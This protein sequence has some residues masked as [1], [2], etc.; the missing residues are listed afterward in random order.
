[1]IQIT[2]LKLKIDHTKEDLKKQI[3]KQLKIQESDIIHFSI[4]K[5]SIDARKKNE[6]SIHNTNYVYSLEVEVK[7]EGKIV[8]KLHNSNIT[9]GERQKYSYRPSGNEKLKHRP[10]IAGFGPAGLFCGL[11][12]AREGYAPIILE[13]G[14]EISNRVKA[15]EH[16]WQTNELDENSNV[17]FGEGGAGTFSDG[18]LNTLVKD[19]FGRGR[20]VLEIF[21][22]HGAPEEIL[23]LNKPHIGTDKLQGVVQGIRKEIIALGGEVRFRT[24]LTD[25]FI[26]KGRLTGVELNHKEVL[27]CN[28]L[29]LAVGHSARDTFELIYK[30]G[31]DMIQKSF[32]VGVRIQHPQKLIS[33]NQYG[34]LYE[35]LPAADYKLSHQ[36]SSGRGVYSFCM[37]PGGFVV[38]SSSEQGGL[39]VNG[40]SNHA[41]DEENAN[42]ALIV[43]V[44][45]EDFPKANDIPEALSGIEY[46]RIL[47]KAAYKTGK[48]VI[49][50]QLF[51]DLCRN[52]ENDTIGHIKPII[53]GQYTF[54]NL[55]E[56]LPDYI[57]DTLIEGV[58]AFDKKIPG[59]AD[60]EAI[61]AGVESRTSSPIRIIRNEEFE[62]NISGIYPC[63]EGAGYAGG[64]TSAA[65]DGIKVY[66][67]IA[68]RYKAV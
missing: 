4:V 8:K 16:F 39:V 68:S 50:V 56:C 51:G 25:L 9:I 45:P 1:M 64:I 21:A 22:E 36:A 37:C 2:Q 40:M 66:E 27:E 6:S 62:S 35:K 43:T 7:D 20:K 55:R 48:G 23:Y 30:K 47:E 58:Q 29:V 46:Q 31:L 44:T 11:M 33:H 49:P 32:A 41:R 61:L 14:D 54:A 63:G 26:E 67:A 34:D 28:T 19:Q 17:Q 3:A 59:F 24:C 5:K 13:R 38:N 12:L 18:K 65:M 52:Q 15:V 53:K 10:V 60:E 57:T 42:S